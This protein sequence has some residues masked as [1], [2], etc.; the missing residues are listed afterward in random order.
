[1]EINY[2]TIM[3]AVHSEKNEGIIPEGCALSQPIP[4]IKSGKL[5]VNFMVLEKRE[6]VLWP[7]YKFGIPCLI[8]Y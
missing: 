3:A 1:M 8:K 2:S 5:S 6:G 7:M 4:E